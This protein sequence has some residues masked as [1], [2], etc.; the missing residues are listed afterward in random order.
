M[1]IQFALM[2]Q[3]ALQNRKLKLSE[4]QTMRHSKYVKLINNVYARPGCGEIILLQFSF[5]YLHDG[6]SA[7][8][9]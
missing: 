7:V 8:R 9:K 6:F 2:R 5:D 4:A 3:L 1:T